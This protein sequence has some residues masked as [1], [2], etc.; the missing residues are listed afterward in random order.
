MAGPAPAQITFEMIGPGGAT[1]MS[2]DGTVVVGNTIGS[3]ETFRWTADTGI[4]TLGRVA[5][6]PAGSPDVSADGLRVSATI[7]SE[8]G[9]YVTQGLWTFGI[10]WQELMPP[11]L[12]DGGLL[13]N[14]YGSAWGLSDDG[15]TV[16]GL[17]WR[18]GQPDGLAHA[19]AWYEGTGLVDL[20]SDG[21]NSRAND[22]NYD[23]SIIV[24]WDEDPDFGYWRPA[25]W[26]GGEK[27][28]LAEHEVFLQASAVN[29]DGT[30]VV[31]VSYEPDVNQQVAAAWRWDGTDWVEEKL[32]SLPGTSAGVG[33]AIPFDLT[34][35]GNR[36][37]GYNL[38]TDPFNATGFLW[39]EDTGIIDVEDYLV[40]HGI[41]IDPGFN[42]QSL[43]GVSDDGR[44]MVGLGQDTSVP[45]ET[46]SFLITC[47]ADSDGNADGHVDLQDVALL[48]QC[49]TGPGA[50]GT[51]DGCE[52]FD[53]DCDFDVDATD[54][55]FFA[56]AMTGPA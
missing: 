42:I 52:P 24:G 1:D 8:D 40:D 50:G 38:F 34:A 49:F 41:E 46:R 45:F 31:G 18:P 28:I 13:D 26:V 2:A 6:S 27:T 48:Q 21:G 54:Y 53:M 32:G 43:A 33:Y 25:V 16:T 12:N 23:G 15:S 37:I 20:G 3:Y 55:A 29:P 44:I 22:A 35:N 51:P 7:G 36:I 30:I 47:I 14:S 39:S 4:V 56:D 11:T 5:S 10:G 9:T 19:S 17:Y